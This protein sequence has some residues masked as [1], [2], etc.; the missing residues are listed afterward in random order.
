MLLNKLKKD[1]EGMSQKSDSFPDAIE[2]PTNAIALRRNG[3]YSEGS[4]N[5]GKR[6]GKA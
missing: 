1:L 3:N 2:G 4:R 5:N 6:G